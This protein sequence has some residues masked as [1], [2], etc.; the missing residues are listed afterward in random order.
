VEEE[1][2]VDG[3]LDGRRVWS[4]VFCMK[5]KNGGVVG[6]TSIKLAAVKT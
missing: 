6:G 4:N 3:L 5:G 2:W 1:K